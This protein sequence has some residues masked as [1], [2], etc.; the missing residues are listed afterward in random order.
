MA[1]SDQKPDDLYRYI[2]YL[3]NQLH[4]PG[5]EEFHDVARM[6]KWFADNAAKF[7][8]DIGPQYGDI[9]SPSAHMEKLVAR[10]EPKTRFDSPLTESTFAPV[11]KEVTE[12]AERIGITLKGP[13]QLL[14]STN[15]AHSSETLA[16]V[17]PRSLFVGTN[18]RVHKVHHLR[19]LTLRIEG[20]ESDAYEV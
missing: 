4:T 8:H 3:Q 17:C 7:D 11:L 13:V 15:L 2:E 19:L 14:T 18:I 1:N 9:G 6:K 12:A 5:W 10:F 16:P 20:P